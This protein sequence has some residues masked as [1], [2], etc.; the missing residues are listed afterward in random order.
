MHEGKTP[1]QEEYM[2]AFSHVVAKVW[3]RQEVEI[4]HKLCKP[5]SSYP[6]PTVVHS[7]SQISARSAE[8]QI[9]KH[10]ILLK[11]LHIHSVAAM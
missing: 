3:T 10:M 6:P 8:I 4:G 1:W 7:A 11:T 9:F 5:T 2:A